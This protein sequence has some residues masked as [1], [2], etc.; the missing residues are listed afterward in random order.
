[1]KFYIGTGPTGTPNNITRL[2]EAVASKLESDGFSLRTGDIG[3]ADA[4]F[5]KGVINKENICIFSA[6]YLSDLE[7]EEYRLTR[8]AVSIAQKVHQADWKSVSSYVRSIYAKSAFLVLGKNLD[9]PSKFVIYWRISKE[10]MASHIEQ[11]M[12]LEHEIKLAEIDTAVLIAVHYKIPVF[13]LA[14]KEHLNRLEDYV[15]KRFSADDE[16]AQKNRKASKIS[17]AK[18]MQV[19]EDPD[20]GDL[21]FEIRA[22]E[23]QLAELEVLKSETEKQIHEFNVRYQRELGPLIEELLGLRKEQLRKEA[24]ENPEKQADYEEAE[25]DYEN[26]RRIYEESIKE[27]LP[28]LRQEEQKELKDKFRQACKL[29]HPDV[30]ADEFREEAHALF[31]ELKNAYERSDLERVKEILCSLEQR[32]MP[33][34]GMVISDKEKLY[35]EI[36]RLKSTIQAVRQQIEELKQTEAYQTV[37]G[38]D[39]WNHYFSELKAKL[40][41]EIEMCRNDDNE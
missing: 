33:E 7:T 30:V 3:K 8:K 28:K 38:T 4:A 32:K 34:R 13:N 5:S 39:D 6:K 14:E 35:A 37:S 41:N 24:E 40:E 21:R 23:K 1:M 16:G 27:D 26:Y 11:A 19:Y 25:A 18:E 22:L 36:S 2:M 15:G 12:H 31:T 10:R 9:T 20:V 17:G 29:C